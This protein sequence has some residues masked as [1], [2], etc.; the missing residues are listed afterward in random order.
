MLNTI[1]GTLS[2]GVAAST[3]SYESIATVNST[4]SSVTLTFNSIPSGYASLQ[5]RGLYSGDG[6]FLMTINGSSSAIYAQHLLKGDGSS[7]SASG[8]GYGSGYFNF[9]QTPTGSTTTLHA[10]ICWD[11][12]CNSGCFVHYL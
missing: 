12:E 4:G 7:A 1:L 6:G 11:L 9:T 8:L 3:S 5:I 2:S 10:C